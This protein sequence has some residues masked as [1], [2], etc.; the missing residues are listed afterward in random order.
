[1][2]ICKI[3]VSSS[4]ASVED[5]IQDQVEGKSDFAFDDSK[6]YQLQAESEYG[7]LLCDQASEPTEKQEGF[8][9]RGS[10][11]AVYKKSAGNTLFVRVN[12]DGSDILKVSVMED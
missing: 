10:Q 7:V 5:L 2:Y 8:V 12:G 11:V 4:W 6:E 3:D 1:M 9:I